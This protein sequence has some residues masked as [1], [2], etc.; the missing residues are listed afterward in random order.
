MI[1]QE[2]SISRVALSLITILGF[3]VLVLAFIE[4]FA[5]GDALVLLLLFAYI[6]VMFRQANSDSL[7]LFNL[8]ALLLGFLAVSCTSFF[9]VIGV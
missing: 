6:L 3:V 8:T 1:K 7:K 2:T 4:N 9:T 5:I